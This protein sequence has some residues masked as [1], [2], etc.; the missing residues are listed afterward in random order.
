LKHEI[1]KAY[2]DFPLLRDNR[3][4]IYMDN[5][6]TTQKP[7]VVLDALQNYYTEC[8][9]NVYRAIYRWG[10]E[11]TRRF[12]QA[13]QK[14]ASFINAESPE[15]VIFTSGTTDS[16]NLAATTLCRHLIKKG[17]EIILS[18]ME[19]HSNLVPWQIQAEYSGAV[20]KFIPV[21]KKGELNLEE[22][23]KL[24]S[25]R[26]KILAI[27]QMSN[28]LGTV[29]P[30]KEIIS[31]AHSHGVKVLIDAAQSAPHMAIDVQ[32]LDCDLLAFSGHKMYGPTGIGVLY[33]KKELLEELPPYRGGGEMIRS[34]YL[35]HSEW[36]TLPHKFEAG[37]PNIAG[38]IGLGAALDY[39]NSWGMEEIEK[40]EA[41]LTHKLI[42]GIDSL[43]GYQLYGHA[44]KRGGIAAFT[45]EGSHSHDLTQFL[46]SRGFALR[47]GHHCAH[48]L[49]RK[50][51]ALSTTRA[52]ISFYNT[53]LEIDKLIETLN[54]AGDHLL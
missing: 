27:T 23:E 39:I 47:A 40:R 43:K 8:N 51:N 16:I 53:E 31:K 19:H 46:D 35:D 20:L 37:T 44:R 6:A 9:S 17:D 1:E 54:Q 13:R 36:N 2:Y 33:G 11:S 15:Q 24:W 14:T 21:N 42:Q 52:S 48:P 22:L 34:V 3:E 30:V 5:A 12:E 38:V 50:L 49:A 26:T 10:E 25:P 45:K 7:K 4:Y 18:E 28:V 41:V 29:N 32:N